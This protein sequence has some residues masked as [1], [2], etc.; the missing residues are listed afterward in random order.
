MLEFSEFVYL[1]LQKT[2]STFLRKKLIAICD[3]QAISLK[4]HR[5]LTSPTSKRRIMTIRNPFKYYI[6]LW[7]Y[8]LSKKGGFYRNNRNAISRAYQDK[9]AA[10]FRCFLNYA[11]N[12]ER[13]VISAPDPILDRRLRIGSVVGSARIDRLD[14]RPVQTFFLDVYTARIIRMVVPQDKVTAFWTGL[15]GD[16][17][18]GR[19]IAALEPYLPDV[20]FRTESLNADFHEAEAR[21]LLDFIPLKRNWTKRLAVDSRELNTSGSNRMR[22]EIFDDFYDDWSRGKLRNASGIALELCRRAATQFED[23]SDSAQSAQ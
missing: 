4:K 16:H 23:R 19:L 21:G 5:P 2:G 14:D 6:S 13:I 17:S 7:M 3:E 22:P 11:L 1:D 18:P 10:S 8:G 20:Y 9:T 15:A 12:S